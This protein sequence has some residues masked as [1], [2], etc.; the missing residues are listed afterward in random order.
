MISALQIGKAAI[1]VPILQRELA[2]TLV[3]ASWIVGAYGVLGAVGGLPAGILSSMFERP[4]HLDRGACGRR[5]RQHCRRVR[6]ERQRSLIAT[7]VLEGCG[8]LAASLAVPRLLRAVTAPK[9]L[10]AGAG[11]VCRASAVRLGG[12]DARGPA[13][14]V[15]SG[16]R[17]SG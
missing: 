14:D 12:H 9:D 11:G 8:S 4:R 17:G 16:G 3:A 10:A 2:L 1:A 5:H 13:R 6:R 7:R 15:R